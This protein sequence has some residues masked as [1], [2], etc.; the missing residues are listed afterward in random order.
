[1]N[2]LRRTDFSAL[3]L[4]SFYYDKYDSLEVESTV[5]DLEKELRD[6]CLLHY[7]MD[8]SVVQ[9][10]CGGRWT[11]EHRRTNQMLQVM[12]HILPDDL[13]LELAAV[14]VDGIP[15]LLNAELPS[16][17]LASFLATLNLPT[18]AKI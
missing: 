6:A 7:D 3:Q 15:N 2:K 17:E 10:Y 14:M 4:L 5:N 13:F 18:V 1:M 11:G 9:Q 12:S 16:E 8:L